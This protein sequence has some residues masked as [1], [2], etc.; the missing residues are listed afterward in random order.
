MK[1]S[2][3][4]AQQGF[5]FGAG[6]FLQDVCCV[7]DMSEFPNVEPEAIAEK[8]RCRGSYALDVYRKCMEIWE[9]TL[10]QEIVEELRKLPNR[11]GMSA[12]MMAIVLGEPLDTIESDLQ[13]AIN[14]AGFSMD[15]LEVDVAA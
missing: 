10:D 6:N 7:F 1:P 8:L 2:Y 12:E 15:Q 3:D 13:D 9:E 11:D 14:H 5:D 4:P